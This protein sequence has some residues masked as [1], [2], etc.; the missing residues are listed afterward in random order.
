MV[1]PECASAAKAGGLG[2]VVSGLSRELEQRGNTV[3]IIVPKY[4]SLRYSD[5]QD[6][7]PAHRDVPVPW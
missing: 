5:V 1:A 6:L 3:E 4:A 2:D 7:Q